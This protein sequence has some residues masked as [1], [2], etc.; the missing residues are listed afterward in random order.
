M[1]LAE[2][3]TILW[4]Q[5]ELLNLLLFK[6]DVESMV[7]TA[8]KTRWLGAATHEVQLVIEQIQ[9]IELLRSIEVDEVAAALGLP[10]GPSLSDLIDALDEPWR[11]VYTEHRRALVGIAAEID[12]AVRANKE[13]L[14]SGQRAVQEALRIVSNASG[15][16][17]SDGHAVAGGVRTRFVDEAV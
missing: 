9:E 3:S 13:L 5:R 12:A 11:E 17:G 1:G 14:T 4:R 15:L 6:L 10:P 7:L 2:T 16:Y 8:G